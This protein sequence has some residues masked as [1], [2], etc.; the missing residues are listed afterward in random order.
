MSLWSRILAALSPRPEHPW[1]SREGHELR[2]SKAHLPLAITDGGLSPVWVYAFDVAIE[3][4]NSAVG[5]RLFMP[6]VQPLLIP[7]LASIWEREPLKGHWPDGG[8][9]F[10]RPVT[11]VEMD[12]RHQ[13]DVRTGEILAAR[14]DV[15]PAAL[16]PQWR[17]LHALHELYHVLGADHDV[18]AGSIM[19]PKVTEGYQQ[20]KAAL[21]AAVR[22]RYGG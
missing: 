14:I 12:T 11:A 6:G 5:L 4:L 16:V 22:R 1:L 10:L 18:Q 13:Y 17:E 19:L 21:I 15:P 7:S 2:W 8:N 3:E 20:A 9:V